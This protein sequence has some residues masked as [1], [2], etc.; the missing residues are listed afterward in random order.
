MSY[1]S[2]FIF[3]WLTKETA[4]FED[5]EVQTFDTRYLS[6]FFINFLLHIFHANIR[7]F[8]PSYVKR[9]LKSTLIRDSTKMH[10]GA[11]C[12]TTFTLCSPAWFLTFTKI[13]NMNLYMFQKCWN[14]CIFFLLYVNRWQKWWTSRYLK[15]DIYW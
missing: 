3:T 15:W 4:I 1:A 14:S 8:C 9:L 7:F 5:F 12:V 2:N 11:S 13:I 10:Y 6:R